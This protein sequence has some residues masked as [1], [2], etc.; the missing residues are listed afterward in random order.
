M[1]FYIELIL[2]VCIFS[3]FLRGSAIATF[4]S[5]VSD[6]TLLW[7]WKVDFIFATQVLWWQFTI[8]TY[9]STLP[10]SAGNSRIFIKI[11]QKS[12]IDNS[13]LQERSFSQNFTITS[14]WEI[15]LDKVVFHTFRRECHAS[16]PGERQW[17][18]IKVVKTHIA[19]SDNWLHNLIDCF[20]NLNWCTF[21]FNTVKAFICSSFDII[22]KDTSS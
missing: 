4:Y 15:A 2:R 17:P 6:R 18:S 1:D 5:I 3:L 16:S 9:M 10:N 7:Q 20:D 19:P 21:I 11:L 22:L 8:D 13:S 14:R 12:C